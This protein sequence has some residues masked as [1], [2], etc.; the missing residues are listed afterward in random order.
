MIP[1]MPLT[2]WAMAPGMRLAWDVSL[3]PITGLALLLQQL[4]SPTEGSAAPPY[5]LPLLGSR[6][7]CVVLAWAAR[8]FR[9][10]CV[11]YRLADPFA[12]LF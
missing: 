9:R 1:L 2:F 4:M 8:R 12:V 5:R 7:V 10:E 6:I 3:I 11:L